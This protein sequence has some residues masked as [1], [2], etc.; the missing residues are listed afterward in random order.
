MSNVNERRYINEKG[1]TLVKEFEGCELEA[2]LC[3]ANVWT[4]GYG[5]TRSVAV[6]QIISEAE[7]EALLRED[8]LD[9]EEAVNKL[10]KVPMN[11]NQFSALVSLAFNIGVFVALGDEERSAFER[12]TLLKIL[13]AGAEAEAVAAQFLR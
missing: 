9:A 1:L 10:V 11:G 2:Y 13:N 7:A 5:H 4:I 8:F 3:P 12:S 6:G